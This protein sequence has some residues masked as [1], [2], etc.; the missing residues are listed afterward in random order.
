MQ[1][2]KKRTMKLWYPRT[3]KRY[4]T[5]G[6]PRLDAAEK[7]VACLKVNGHPNETRHALKCAI[8]K[9]GGHMQ[10]YTRRKCP[11]KPSAT[12]IQRN[13]YECFYSTYAS[14][15]LTFPKIQ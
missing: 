13:I 7:K 15:D 11:S 10:G 12:M 1:F 9:Q 2:A 3:Q 14:I 5:K 6:I 4:V 8:K